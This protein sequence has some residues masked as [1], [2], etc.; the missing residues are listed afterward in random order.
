MI[1]YILNE[2]L[3]WFGWHRWSNYRTNRRHCTRLGCGLHQRLA[4]YSNR[5]HEWVNL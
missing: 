4:F 1:T 3:C 2:W 5:T